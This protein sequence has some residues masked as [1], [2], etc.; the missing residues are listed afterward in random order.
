MKI[1]LT[2]TQPFELL[3]KQTLKWTPE[4]VEKVSNV[5]AGKSI[6]GREFDWNANALL[7]TALQGVYQSNQATVPPCRSTIS[8]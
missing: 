8:S 6:E 1:I 2:S 3:K 4:L 5:P 7:S